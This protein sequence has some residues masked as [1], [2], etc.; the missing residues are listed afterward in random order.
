MR[1]PAVRR[2]REG[3][4]SIGTILRRHPFLVTGFAIATVLTLLFAAR[5]AWHV[6]YWSMHENEPIRPWM[7]VG[8]VAHN[9]DLKAKAIDDI[10]KLPKPTGHRPFTL[11]EIASQRGVPVEQVI[12]D[13]ESA[14]SQIKAKE[15]RGKKP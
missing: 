10:A 2:R 8:Y 13:V 5:F 4:R 1:G 12:A 11:A 7:T 15:H 14:I 9:W 3:V 6:V